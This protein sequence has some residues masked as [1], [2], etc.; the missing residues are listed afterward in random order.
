M[1]SLQYLA[2]M[3]CPDIAYVISRL[4]S[5]SS[6]LSLAHYSTAKRVLHYLKET[7]DLGITYRTRAAR[8]TGPN[9]NNFFYGFSD[10]SYASADDLKSISGY[11]FLSDGGAITRGLRKQSVVALSTME[12]EYVAVSKAACN[13]V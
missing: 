6:N 9:D 4:G 2:I 7:R 8:V 1:G 3:T 12:A 11:V 10:A 13:A 5:Y